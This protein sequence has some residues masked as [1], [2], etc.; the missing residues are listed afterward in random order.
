VAEYLCQQVLSLPMH[1]GLMVAQVDYI[2]ACTRA[3]FAV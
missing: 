3:F 2:L 1:P